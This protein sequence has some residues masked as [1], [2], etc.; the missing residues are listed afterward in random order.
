MLPPM[1]LITIIPWNT[2]VSRGTRGN[3]P[4][5][6]GGVCQTNLC[7]SVAGREVVILGIKS[8][9]QISL[10]IREALLVSWDYST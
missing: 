8:L 2:A 4:E 6:Y 5:E 1:K 7:C 9:P 3:N 10:F